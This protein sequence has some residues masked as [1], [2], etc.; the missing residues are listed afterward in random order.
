MSN[1]SDIRNFLQTMVNQSKEKPVPRA[2]AMLQKPTRADQ[3]LEAFVEFHGKHPEV[4]EL[5]RKTTFEVLRT[6]RFHYSAKAVFERIRWYFDV[7]VESGEQIKLNNNFTPYYARMFH[8]KY[9]GHDGFFLNR[10]R[11]SDDADGKQYP[12]TIHISPNA[13]GESELLERLAAL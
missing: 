8:A 11:I 1:Q 7:E 10:K 3:I 12:D 6:G 5:F 9:P 2:K 13:T 4:W